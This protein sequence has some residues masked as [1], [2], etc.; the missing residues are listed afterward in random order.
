MTV[1]PASAA[2]LSVIEFPL[3][4]VVVALPPTCGRPSGSTLPVEEL[5]DMELVA[6]GVSPPNTA[7]GTGRTS[8]APRWGMRAVRAHTKHRVAEAPIAPQPPGHKDSLW[9]PRVIRL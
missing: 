6:A 8:R 5:A 2:D 9:T 7:S 1:A 3:E 4:E